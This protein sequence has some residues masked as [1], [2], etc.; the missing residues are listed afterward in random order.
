MTIIN[1]IIDN[2]SSD[3]VLT[4][5]YNNSLALRLDVIMMKVESGIGTLSS[6]S[7]SSSSTTNNKPRDNVTIGK[8]YN[9]TNTVRLISLT[10]NNTVCIE[11]VGLKLG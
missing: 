6:S 5:I 1:D 7:S 10:N 8:K 9:K 3:F 4:V 11:N 2:H